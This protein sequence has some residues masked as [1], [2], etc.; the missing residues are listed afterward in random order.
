MPARGERR[1]FGHPHIARAAFVERPRQPLASCRSDQVGGKRSA[2][3]LIEREGVG[4]R[5]TLCR[6]RAWHEREQH[7]EK[8]AQ[9]HAGHRERQSGHGATRGRSGEHDESSG[10]ASIGTMTW[11]NRTSPPRPPPH[12]PAAHHGS[13][14]L[15]Q[16]HDPAATGCRPPRC[17]HR[18]SHAAGGR[19]HRA[20]RT[21]AGWRGRRGARAGRGWHGNA[22]AYVAA[23]SDVVATPCAPRALPLA[24]VGHRSARS[25]SEALCVTPPQVAP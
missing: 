2:H 12:V 3:H 16:R 24:H 15:R 6:Q 9:Q 1:P 5:P 20:P 22:T 7:G 4:L 10:R 8:A 21:G 19:C 14:S 11:S 25:D 13:P 23:T 17:T 18:H